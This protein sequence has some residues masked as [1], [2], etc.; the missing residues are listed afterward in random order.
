[1]S[2]NQQK[3]MMNFESPWSAVLCSRV[4]KLSK[5]PNLLHYTCLEALSN[6]QQLKSTGSTSISRF[7]RHAHAHE[8]LKFWF[9]W[10]KQV[11]ILA[12]WMMRIKN[13]QEFLMFV[14]RNSRFKERESWE[15][16]WIFYLKF[17]VMAV[18]IR[19]WAYILHANDAENQFNLSLIMI[20]E[21]WSNLQKMKIALPCP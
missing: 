12:Q 1:M 9:N 5:V 4:L 8:L 7:H 19:V 17:S 20:S 15:N 10:S 2:W 14:W 6:D 13:I 3:E 16:S 18:M 21:L 11:M